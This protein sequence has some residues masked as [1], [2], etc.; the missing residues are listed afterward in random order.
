METLL[1]A[2][3]FVVVPAVLAVV[4]FVYACVAISRIAME[5]YNL[6]LVSSLSFAL[7]FCAVVFAGIAGYMSY[8]TATEQATIPDNAAL[9][10]ALYGL[11]A[12]I[13]AGIAVYSNIAKSNLW[14][15]FLFTLV[16]F[17]IATGIVSVAVWLI[18]R[19][20]RRNAIRLQPS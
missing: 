17:A 3:A 18:A 12:I 14:F 6:R 20:L 15:G 8:T 2:E 11:S 5:K 4:M 9:N 13:C 10:M 16:Q 7:V 1:E 19:K